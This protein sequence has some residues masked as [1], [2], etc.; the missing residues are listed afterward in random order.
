MPWSLTEIQ[1][2]GAAPWST[3]LRTWYWGHARVGPYTVVWFDYVTPEGKEGGSTYISRNGTILSAT[4]DAGLKVRPSAP[5]DSIYPPTPDT[6]PPDE[7]TFSLPV[8]GRSNM[9]LKTVNASLAIS[10]P[11]VFVRWVSKVVGEFDGEELEGVA[12]Y[13]QF[14]FDN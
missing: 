8:P 10:R 14:T 5:A 7:F 6:P 11:G 1:N 2:W 12:M 13:E 9:N 4:C 3:L